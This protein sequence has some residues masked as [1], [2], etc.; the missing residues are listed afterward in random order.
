[1]RLAQCGGCIYVRGLV[2]F[3]DFSQSGEREKREQKRKWRKSGSSSFAAGLGF[4][5]LAASFSVGAC[6]GKRGTI[7]IFEW[8]H[9]W[10]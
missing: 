7:S 8:Q 2:W 9:N 6:E 10:W 4:A 1:M 3:P 5:L